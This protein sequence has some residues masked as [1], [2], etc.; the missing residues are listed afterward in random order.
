MSTP[1][2]TID[3]PGAPFAPNNALNSSSA[4]TKS[5]ASKVNKAPTA[6]ADD[7]VDVLDMNPQSAFEVFAG[8]AMS[9]G[10]VGQGIPST[11]P[12]GAPVEGNVGDPSSSILY[13]LSHLQSQLSALQRRISSLDPASPGCVDSSQ[14][15]SYASSI[16]SSL[17]SASSS[18]SASTSSAVLTSLRDDV[19]RRLGAAKEGNKVEARRRS[20]KAKEDSV[21]YEIYAP[22]LAPQGSGEVG[23]D[24]IDARLGAVEAALSSLK[25]GDIEGLKDRLSR[26]DPGDVEGATARARVLKAEL[27]AALKLAARAARPGPRLG[28]DE[29]K[30]SKMYDLISPALE[31]G[32][33]LPSL[34]SRLRGLGDLHAGA[35]R[36]EARLAE[37]EGGVKDAT[38]VLLGVEE[39]VRR[40][41]VGLEEAVRKIEENLKEVVERVEKV[42]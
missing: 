29:D 22:S 2:T 8:K 32:G 39:G 21:V 6:K 31:V 18:L 15:T 30:V 12:V 28:S 9:T 41:E 33:R 35:S 23:V 19:S 7:T 40:L 26:V 34:L 37:A 3:S 4:S 1:L 24:A 20:N 17:A 5:T 13:E 16:S 38:R 10:R 36:L 11:A 27:E 42:E 25:P 14:L